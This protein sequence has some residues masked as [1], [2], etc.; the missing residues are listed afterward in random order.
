MATDILIIRNKA[1]AATI[2][3]HA[4]GDG[5][6]SHLQSK[7]YSVTDLSDEQTTPENVSYWLSSSNIR[8]K[9][10]IIGLDHG[11]CSAFYG[12][13]NGA[14]TAVITKSNCEDLTKEL[15]MYTFAC[16]T[17]GDN[18][19]GPTAISK[20]CYSWL[21]Y[22]VPVYVFTNTNSSL[23]KTLK[24]VIWSYVTALAE[25]KTVEQAETV[26]R[27]N[28]QANVSKHSLF[29]FNL[30]KLLLRKRSANM[31]INSHN[32]AVTWRRNVKVD[33]LYAYGPQNRNVHVHFAG[34]GWKRLWP[35]HDSQVVS[36][37]AQL[38]FA[39]AKGRG[40]T[41]LEDDGRIKTLYA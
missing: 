10:L 17:N 25:G 13:Q 39:K 40:V 24:D 27:N 33:G 5:L 23:F 34:L 38:T 26:L 3:T 32:R 7:G 29:S 9:K 20:G 1:D 2:A 16:S 18:C 22:I 31:T 30:S 37:M 41:F 6:K 36:M 4:I 14:V 15:H 21:G 28:Y 12:E 11:S 35:S 8:T 19:V